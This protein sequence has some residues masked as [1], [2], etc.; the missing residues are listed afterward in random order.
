MASWRW[1]DLNALVGAHTGMARV[2]VLAL[3]IAAGVG[4]A[5]AEEAN[6]RPLVWVYGGRGGSP[7]RARCPKHSYVAGLRVFRAE[8]C[9]AGVALL[10][11]P[12]AAPSELQEGELLG[13]RASRSESVQCEEGAVGVGIWGGAG[14][15]VDRISMM[16]AARAA[17][18]GPVSHLRPV[19][20]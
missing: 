8:S 15:L 6:L 17:L 19:G 3:G 18:D 5:V 9:V 7:A 16:C 2:L 1:T 10:C 11:R 14:S 13:V 12:D 20:G 4:V